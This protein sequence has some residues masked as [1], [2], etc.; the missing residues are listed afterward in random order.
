MGFSKK[1]NLE[2]TWALYD[3]IMVVMLSIKGIPLMQLSVMPISTIFSTDV[4]FL[5]NFLFDCG[6]VLLQHF[7]ILNCQRQKQTLRSCTSSHLMVSDFH[8]ASSPA[9]LQMPFLKVEWYLGHL[10]VS[11]WKKKGVGPRFLEH[12]NVLEKLT[13]LEW[14]TT[15]NESTINYLSPL[16]QFKLCLFKHIKQSLT[17]LVQVWSLNYISVYSSHAAPYLTV[18]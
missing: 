3:S 11:V 7:S 1:S 5:H 18:H 2:C 16:I 9:K 14:T 6:I 17:L 4:F 13:I 15:R 12:F 8:S 10:W